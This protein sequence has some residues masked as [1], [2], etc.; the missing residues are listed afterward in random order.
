MAGIKEGGREGGKE[1]GREGKRSNRYST[2]C[3]IYKFMV[4]YLTDM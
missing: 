2:E 1:G 3:L 4:Q